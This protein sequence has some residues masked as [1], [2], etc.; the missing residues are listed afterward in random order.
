MKVFLTLLFNLYVF[1]GYTQDILIKHINVINVIE[2]EIQY[3]RTILISN[4]KIQ[5]ISTHSIKTKNAIVINGKNKFLIPGLWDMHVHTVDSSYL[6]LF[7]INGVT[8]IRDMGGA[9]SSPNNGCESIDYTKLMTW[10][11][12]IQSGFLIGP[13]MVISGPPVS[14]TGWATSI[15]INTPESAKTA[16]RKLKEIGVDFIKVYENIPLDT[17]LTLAK[18]AKAAGLSIAG[19]VPIETVPL[20]EASNA[21]QRSIEHIRDPLLL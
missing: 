10:R 6:N 7:I 13:R 14:N 3:D 18:E 12:L 19:H 1:S 4:G 16:V 5:N 21:S 15:N 2:K 9:A 17:Y 11:K 20:T 8:G